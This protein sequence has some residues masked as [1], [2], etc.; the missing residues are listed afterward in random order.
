MQTVFSSCF[1]VRLSLLTRSSGLGPISGPALELDRKGETIVLE[2]YAPN[3]LRVTLS[4]KR[5][6]ALAAPGYGIIGDARCGGLERKPDAQADVYQSAR[7]VA[8]V[9]HDLPP[10]Q[11]PLQPSSTSPNT[12]TA[13]LR[14]RTSRF[15]TPEGKQLLEMTGWSQAVPNHKDGTADLARDRRPTDREFYTVGANFVSPDDEHY[16]GLGQ[17]QEGFL[18]HRGHPVRCWARLQRSGRAQ[19]LR[20]V[21]GD[22]QG[23]RA[24][25]G[26]PLE[27]HHRAGLQRAD[28]AGAPRWATAF[29]SS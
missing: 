23:L 12:S 7:M 21:S 9:D 2:P 27:D 3:I 1:L 19:H 4:L 14:A 25:L 18:D 11:P 15:T 16:Y 6:P 17:N 10:A 13:P 8:T 24:G 5:E 22:Q 26:Q 28:H 29:R 20:A